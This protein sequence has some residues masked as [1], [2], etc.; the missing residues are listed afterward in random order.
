MSWAAFPGLI[1]YLAL[2]QLLTLGLTFVNPDIS[3]LLSFDYQSILAGEVW[4]ALSFI[5]IPNGSLSS[6]MGVFSAVIAIFLALLLMTFGDGLERE[7]GIF[8]TSM[9]VYTGWFTCF[10]SSFIGGYFGIDSV[11]ILN[12]T[13][14]FS[15]SIML[16]FAVFYP[17]FE[18]LLMLII[19][20]KIYLL[21]ILSIVLILLAC[22]K[23]PV[24]FPYVVGC[25]GNFFLF[26]GP[27]GIKSAIRKGGNMK[28]RQEYKNK[29][30]PEGA[31][32]HNCESCG[33][34]EHTHPDRYFR[35]SS[36]GRELCSACLPESEKE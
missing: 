3:R 35:I 5:F 31:A 11:I 2:F 20:V 19:P 4:R 22:I 21:A 24:L 32:F 6:Q 26:I 14:Y 25:L 36:D 33:A 8:R 9:Y 27:S 13:T 15:L 10:I 29:S 7:W 18:L 23:V 28:K 16:A 12:P 30:I 17:K 1:R 34:T